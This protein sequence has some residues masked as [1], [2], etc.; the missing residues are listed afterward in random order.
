VTNPS[1]Y[2]SLPQTFRI[3][4]V[5]IPTRRITA[6]LLAAIAAAPAVAAM[7]PPATQPAAT[8]PAPTTQPSA[9]TQSAASS[10]TAQ[11]AA[12]HHAIDFL[13]A[14]RGRHFWADAAPRGQA[15]EAGALAAYTLLFAKSSLDDSRLSETSPELAPIVHWLAAATFTDTDALAWQMRGL[16]LVPVGKTEIN[17][18]DADVA[19]F[20]RNQLSTG[21]IPAVID[22]SPTEFPS[23]LPRADL[24]RSDIVHTGVA[25]SAL[26]LVGQDGIIV[27]RNVWLTGQRYLGNAMRDQTKGGKHAFIEDTVA[28]AAIVEGSLSAAAALDDADKTPWADLF[29]RITRLRDD[30]A[31]NPTDPS[32]RALLLAG[33]PAAGDD[34]FDRTAIAKLL[35]Q[36][37]PDG[38]FAGKNPLMATANAVLVLCRLRT[39]VGIT[40]MA[41]IDPAAA[42]LWRNVLQ[43][44]AVLS[45]SFDRPL[46]WQRGGDVSTTRGV[47]FIPDATFTSIDA[48]RW[49]QYRA[50]VRAGG[51]IVSQSHDAA[52]R[53]AWLHT[54]NEKLADNR[55]ATIAV[56]FNDPLLQERIKVTSTDVVALSNGVRSWWVDVPAAADADVTKHPLHEGTDTAAVLL[57]A[58]AYNSGKGRFTNSPT[59]APPL[60]DGAPLHVTLARLSY[61]GNYDPEPG[62]WPRLA[63]SAL[64]GIVID[65]QNE[66]I[67]AL[68][69]QHTQVAH[70]T[71]T[72]AATFPDADVATLHQFITAGG[73][74]LLDAAAS[75]PAFANS[76]DTLA[77][78]IIPDQPLIELPL[79]CAIYNGSLIGPPR[80]DKISYRRFNSE[81]GHT[82]RRPH[83]R[84][85]FL[86]GRYAIIISP[87]DLTFGLLNTPTDH[88]PGYTPAVARALTLAEL[89]Y[90]TSQQLPI[91]H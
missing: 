63:A 75:D 1:G 36:Q 19:A 13:L 23:R 5:K 12:L 18:L 27:P 29:P 14:A 48:T 61:A 76:A 84:G 49:Q 42:P 77:K 89:L 33:E 9:A 17:T 80:L 22:R 78:R 37:N 62:A 10:E 53:P 51:L 83:L 43:F 58:I 30:F 11:I 82:D 25:L 40:C 71:G 44:R 85:I 21:G 73:T 8:Q 7:P 26:W 55:Y 64:P 28:T 20:A 68:D 31:T 54:I 57:N 45:H 90:A 79:N 52:T 70:L 86:D 91:K 4:G 15:E 60:P 24:V 16:L 59:S 67:S 41:P 6:L 38:S 34:Q 65:I 2:L 69:P 32:C 35:A 81:L 74:L 87:D 66:A 47:V 56:P 50:C 39:P 46:R 3:S 88:V 72:D